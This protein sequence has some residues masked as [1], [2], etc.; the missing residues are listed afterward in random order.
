MQGRQKLVGIPWFGADTYQACRA[1]MT[2]GAG[3]P[4]YY[5]HWLAHAEALLAE[6]EAVGHRAL[7]V[8]VEA[9]DFVAWCKARNLV[10]DAKARVRFANQIAFQEAG[11]TSGGGGPLRTLRR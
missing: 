11:F 8:P 6:V 10:P 2:D 4:D 9:K 5:P 3:M 7:R 1:V